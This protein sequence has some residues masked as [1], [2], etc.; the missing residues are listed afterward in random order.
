V[1]NVFALD[2]NG[3]VEEFFGGYSDWLEYHNSLQ[4]EAAIV[5]KATP[6]VEKLAPV[7]IAPKKKKLSFKEQQEFDN[8][9]QLIEI[10]EKKQVEI[11]V[12][13]NEPSFYKQ[14]K[15]T[16]N[17]TLVALKNLEIELARTYSRWEELDETAV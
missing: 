8:L 2:G 11:T 4:A 9:P 3:D 6:K 5:K 10:L 16:I 1:T 17:D 12:K 7:S 15:S 13:M 14:E